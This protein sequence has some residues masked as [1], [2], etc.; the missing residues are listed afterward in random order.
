MFCAR[1]ITADNFAENLCKYGRCMSTGANNSDCVRFRRE[2]EKNSFPS[3]EALYVTLSGFL[4][5]SNLPF[6]V[7]FRT[8]KQSVRRA[9]KRLSTKSATSEAKNATANDL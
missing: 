8:V 1:H 7:Q 9:T 2:F 5:F 6:I 4:T 3:L